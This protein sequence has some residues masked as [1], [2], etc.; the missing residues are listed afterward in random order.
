MTKKALATCLLFL[1]VALTAPAATFSAPTTGR[2]RTVVLVLAPRLSWDDVT[3][4]DMPGLHRLISDGAA[5]DMNPNTLL[6]Q[7]WPD[8]VTRGVLM[9]SAGSSARDASGTPPVTRGEPGFPPE[10]ESSGAAIVYPGLAQQAASM[11]GNAMGTVLGSL[12]QAVD[13]AGGETYA[14]GN[15][16]AGAG[17]GALRDR[18]AAIVAMDRRG[19]VR[20]G[21][22]SQRFVVPDRTA[23]FGVRTD[24]EALSAA[25]VDVAAPRRKGGAAALVVVD[26]GDLERAYVS[27]RD[28]LSGALQSH[29]RVQALESLDAL[30]GTLRSSL[31]SD[32]A[33]IV[34][35]PVA[36][37]S[38][39]TPS[40][41]TPLI[42]VSPGWQGSLTSSSTHRAGV[43]TI[44]DLSVTVLDLLGIPA[45]V[46]MLGDPMRPV[47]DKGAA[48]ERIGHFAE[49]DATARSA[50]A[51]RPRAED[52]FVI[53]AAALLAAGCALL[54]A[55]PG[56]R[57]VIAALTGLL[58]LLAMPVG[59]VLMFLPVRW[60]LTAGSVTALL[61]AT[62][63]AAWTV[64]ATTH[65]VVGLSRAYTWMASLLVEV[66]IIDQWLGAPL[67]FTGMFSFSP[68]WGARYYGISNEMA[69]VL[70]GAAVCGSG[71]LLDSQGWRWWGH[72]AKR[73]GVVALGIVVV[74]TCAAP[75]LGANVG[76]AVWGTVAFVLA[77][78]GM[79]GRRV[80]WRTVLVALV[81]VALLIG[82]F[83][84]F[85]VARSDTAQTHLGRA[86]V[87][88]ER[89]GP[90]ELGLM[91]VRK[92]ETAWRLMTGTAWSWLSLVL[93]AAL[94]VLWFL[95]R[96]ELLSVLAER[97]LFRAGVV[98]CLVA[99]G[100]ALLSEDSG[101]A[102]PAMIMLYPA[103]GIAYVMLAARIEEVPRHG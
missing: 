74:G 12:G 22:V 55:A 60:P 97:P 49:M 42:V 21:D 93:A 10:A 50:D 43:V 19:R 64:A 62:T 51:V 63:F 37:P 92:A 99:A 83:V 41:F 71:L 53:A 48:D 30:V 61:L 35:S 82:T 3:A 45:P 11:A 13:D 2:V 59:S 75:F 100:V 72:W 31:P 52:A 86:L 102:M 89:G 68:L 81:V 15:S 58:F 98:A 20:S 103:I 24:V 6:P 56:R 28:P 57:T 67:S 90:G 33:L 29:D 73:W 32:S 5:A 18:P 66:V 36:V 4:G 7:W 54:F 46:Q 23:A 80:T 76:V 87:S 9:I 16:D 79:S 1:A 26:S 27:R 101:I 84:L 65:I 91:V 25:A 70:V 85:D 69:G 94:A 39:G 88:V 95:R 44:T 96:D 14:Y 8:S 17:P 38:S 40:G 34:A 47:A 77:W 78:T